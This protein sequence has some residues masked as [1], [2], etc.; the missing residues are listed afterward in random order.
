M[1]VHR[2][3]TCVGLLLVVAALSV[4]GCTA[5]GKEGASALPP[6]AARTGLPPVV[7]PDEP[8][9]AAEEM[10]AVDIL[11]LAT[12]RDDARTLSLWL[13]RRFRAEPLGPEPSTD[14]RQLNEADEGGLDLQALI[15][16]AEDKAAFD[17]EAMGRPSAAEMLDDRLTLWNG[18]R[19]V[20]AGG[21]VWLYP[22][23]PAGGRRERDH[24]LLEAGAQLDV[25]ATASADRRYVQLDLRPA[26]LRVASGEWIDQ[27]NCGPVADPALAAAVG[28]AHVPR[29]AV[30]HLAARATED[31]R[32]V[33][34]I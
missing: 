16:S 23:V 20:L 7:L 32:A 33:G 15:L 1:P 6:P 30:Q 11:F 26:A 2:A 21:S 9:A 4:A 29:V 12:D 17:A 34:F 19:S 25:R 10:I 13:K 18:Q 31:R 24:V 14:W 3:P 22:T 8:P 28:E 5:A 27:C